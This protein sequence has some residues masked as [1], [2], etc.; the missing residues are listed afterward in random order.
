MVDAKKAKWKKQQELENI[1][2]YVSTYKLS[3]NEHPRDSLVTNHHA[4][5][6]PLSSH[7]TPHNRINKDLHLRDVRLGTAPE[8]PPLGLVATI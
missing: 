5:P 1:G 4:S 7:F 6:K 2:D 3:Y 8:H